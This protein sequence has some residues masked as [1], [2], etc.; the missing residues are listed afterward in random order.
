MLIV[1]PVNGLN[2]GG[3]NIL[4]TVTVNVPT[5]REPA[6]PACKVSTSLF[7]PVPIVEL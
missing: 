4:S 7:T 3:F 1:M 2:E 5:A 6:F